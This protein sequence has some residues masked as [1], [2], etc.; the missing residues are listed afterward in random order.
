MEPFNKKHI[1]E[2]YIKVAIVTAPILDQTASFVFNK[3]TVILW[4]LQNLKLSLILK[5]CLFQQNWT[6]AVF[7]GAVLAVTNLPE[8]TKEQSKQQNKIKLEF[9]WRHLLT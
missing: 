5:N 7:P 3:N 8:T 1:I 4:L 9:F 6:Q 2:L